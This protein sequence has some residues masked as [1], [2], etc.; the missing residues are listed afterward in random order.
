MRRAVGGESIV[1]VG[2]WILFALIGFFAV[3]YLLKVLT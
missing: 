2:M 3:R 1:G